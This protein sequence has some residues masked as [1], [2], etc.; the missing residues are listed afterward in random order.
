MTISKQN[1]QYVVSGFSRTLVLLVA[2]CSL[3]FVGGTLSAQRGGGP[4]AG[5]AKV[6]PA[7]GNKEAIAEGEKL[8]NETCTSCH[9]KDG[10]GGELGPPV[11]AQNRRYL[12]RTDDEIFDAIKTGI[13]GTQMP[14]FSS[15]FNDDQIWR[16]TA[17]IHGLR[18]TAVDT[19]SSGNV[20]N[21]EAIFWNKG[22]C[23]S[24]HM[25]KAKGGILGPDLSNLGGTRKVQNIV[26]ALT[27]EKHRIMADG[28]THDSTLLPMSSYQPVR[29][30]TSD[31]KV[32]SGILKNEDSFSLQVLGKDDLNIHRFRRR[33]VKVFY[34]PQS[35]MPHD[36]DKRLSS[37]EFQDLMA[38]LTRLYVPPPPPP[39]ARGGGVGG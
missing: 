8:Y 9:G 14:P 27:K 1:A 6:H 25:V 15:Q 10:T 30:T 37:T 12:R 5:G 2:L 21:G 13:T 29:V 20:A 16:I 31:G 35:L 7:I 4:P 23:G 22:N 38:F 36:W 34:D 26:D 18:G 32:I 24:C 11:A 3:L 19:P 17:Y 39:P 33:D 28:G